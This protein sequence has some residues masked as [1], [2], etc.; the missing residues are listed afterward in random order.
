M[1]LPEI[2]FYIPK[3]FSNKESTVDDS[4]SESDIK[5]IKGIITDYTDTLKKS[6]LEKHDKQSVYEL[7]K[8]AEIFDIQKYQ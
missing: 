7:C 8:L 3:N 5:E 2:K 1:Y 4:L 6:M